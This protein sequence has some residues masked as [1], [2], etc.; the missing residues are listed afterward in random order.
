MKGSNYKK[1][2][3][4]FSLFRK[5]ACCVNARAAVSGHESCDL[6]PRQVRLAGVAQGNDLHLA[7]LLKSPERVQVLQSSLP[8]SDY[9]NLKLVCHP[10]PLSLAV[11]IR[12]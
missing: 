12:I 1:G 8:Q 7:A 2:L 3:S 11:L 10:Y 4:L 5:R 6:L 9:C